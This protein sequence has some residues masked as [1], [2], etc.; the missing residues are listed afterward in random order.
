MSEVIKH[1]CGIAFLRLK[2]P[3]SYYQK[4]YG[5]SLYGIEKM[6]LLMQKQINR[7][8]DGAGIANIKIDTSPGE[9]YISRKRALG[10][11]GVEEVFS[12]LFK[13]FELLNINKPSKLSDTDYLKRNHSFTGELFL[14]HLRY[15]TYGK[16]EI[17]ACHPFLRQN[18]WKNRNLIVAGNFNLTNVDELFDHLVELGQHP[19]EKADTVTV[20]EKIGHFL[21]IE[22]QRL[23]NKYKAEGHSNLEITQLISDNL[24]LISILK[25]SAEKWDG[26]YVMSGLIGNGDGFVLRDPN[27]IRPCYYYVDDEVVVSASER[28]VIQT[29]FNLKNDAVRE[30]PPG[31]ALIVKNDGT[32]FVEEI[33]TPAEYKPCSFERIYF[34]RGNDFEIHNERKQLGR[35]LAHRVLNELDNDVQNTVFTYIPNTAELAYSGLVDQVRTL[36]GKKIRAEK[37]ILKETKQRTFITEDN[38]RDDLVTQGYDVTYG[39]V[40]TTDT[41]VVVDDSIVRGTTLKKSVLKIL[42]RLSP[43]KIIFVSSA[44][45]VR[46]PDCYGIY[47]TK[48]N[49]FVAFNSL[50]TKLK[51]D[52]KEGLIDSVYKA[53]KQ[54]EHRH[55]SEIKNYFSKLYNQYSYE[56]I[57]DQIANQITPKNYAIPV[58]MI[59]QTVE[60]LHT[61]CPKNKGDWYFTGDY[62]TPGGL[63]V[64]NTAFVNWYEGN[65]NANSY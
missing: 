10:K 53:C 22:N 56:E 6:Q 11:N 31:H 30:L 60:G 63:K 40:K 47:M 46:Y 37:V 42:E 16:N 12:S 2:K 3:L 29:A 45:Q 27:G 55:R 14:G 18:N 61:S 26:G 25:E 19:K 64:L 34:S 1:E 54:Q 5:S 8:Q 65:F 15:A 4:K 38:E 21:D 20:M 24:D 58:K 9:R 35:E 52:N 33:I 13:Q 62:P 7:G 23:F 57:S 59:Y 51:E 48:M 50:I 39:V 36:T 44:P 41:L 28:P 32:H 49:E 17:E 43:R